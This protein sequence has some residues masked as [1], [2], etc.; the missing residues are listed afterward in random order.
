[1]VPLPPKTRKAPSPSLAPPF[2]SPCPPS[3][4]CEYCRARDRLC[5]RA[6]R[7]PCLRPG[8]GAREGAKEGERGD[9]ALTIASVSLQLR[10]EF[11]C[12]AGRRRGACVLLLLLLREGEWVCGRVDR[13]ERGPK[14]G[15][16]GASAR[17]ARRRRRRRLCRPPLPPRPPPR[18]T[19]SGGRQGGDAQQRGPPVA[20]QTENGSGRRLS[21]ADDEERGARRRRVPETPAPLAR[22]G[23]SASMIASEKRPAP[24]LLPHAHTRPPTDTPSFA[25]IRP[26]PLAILPPRPSPSTTQPAFQKNHL[27]K[28]RIPPLSG[29]RVNLGRPFCPADAPG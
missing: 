18:H 27:K 20:S 3:P 7:C 29:G 5:E 15:G 26:D 28:S 11:A 25:S 6:R 14:R 22:P 4:V 17:P 24:H 1:M 13:R 19:P 21:P 2:G 8:F 23:E 9:D 16:G 10:G 12:V